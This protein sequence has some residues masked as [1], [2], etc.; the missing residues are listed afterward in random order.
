M[1]TRLPF[2]LVGDFNIDLKID[3]Y[4]SRKYTE[5]IQTFNCIQTV[6]HP[7]RISSF[8]KSLIDHCICSNDFI[9][10]SNVLEF[11]IADHQPLLLNWH[12][13]RNKDTFKSEKLIKTN[14][15]KLKT[16][17]TNDHLGI[18]TLDCNDTFN[19]LHQKVI[20]AV[21]NSKYQTSKKNTPKKT[22]HY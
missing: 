10:E 16:S 1:T 8:K 18:E 20:N 12:L 21:N 9:L 6:T 17:L 15:K 7:T 3:N 13:K 19:T 11:P 14:Y 22:L 2:V 4:I 5:L